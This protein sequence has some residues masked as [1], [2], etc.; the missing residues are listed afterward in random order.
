[1]VVGISVVVVAEL[2]RSV[3]KTIWHVVK[4]PLGTPH[5]LVLPES[6]VVPL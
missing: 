2:S 3:H 1:M 4:A 6:V 5:V